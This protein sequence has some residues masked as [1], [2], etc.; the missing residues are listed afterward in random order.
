MRWLIFLFVFIIL[1]FLICSAWGYGQFVLQGPLTTEKTIV[2]PRGVGIERIA[3]ILGRHNIIKIPLVFSVGARTVGAGKRLK[4]GEFSFSKHLSPRAVLNILQNGKQVVRRLTVAEG[5]TNKQILEVLNGTDG[6]IGEAVMPLSEGELLPETY[7]F[8]YGDNRNTLLRRMLVGMKKVLA[9]SWQNRSLKLPISSI[10]DAVILA[11]IVEKETGRSAERARVAGVFMN[12]LQLNMKLQSDPTV[13]FSIT[14]GKLKLKR[15]LT[16]DDLKTR[17]PY[18]TYYI[19]GLP[20][21]PITNPGLAAIKA[22]V[23]PINSDE[24]YFVADGKGGHLF[25]KNLADHNKNVAKW[26]Q[27]I[28]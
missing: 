23:N 1:V 17:S 24:L 22:V 7:Y 10:K 19:K 12:R 27:L 11:S 20:P 2:I 15:A 8:S 28:K 9:K 3:M 25:A 21:G 14:K 26:R 5:L 16:K 13:I 4:A 6:L 18:N